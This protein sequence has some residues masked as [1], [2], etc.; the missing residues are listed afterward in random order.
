MYFPCKYLLNPEW[1]GS[2]PPQKKFMYDNEFCE[3]KKK[4]NIP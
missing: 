1:A 3:L 4:K 2:S